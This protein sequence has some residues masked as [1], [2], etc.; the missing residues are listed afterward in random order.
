[1]KFI[2]DRNQTKKFKNISAVVACNNL[3]SYSSG[4]NKFEPYTNVNRYPTLRTVN[5]PFYSKKLNKPY[6]LYSIDRVKSKHRL[7]F[8]KSFKL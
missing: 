1:M 5:A 6:K 3:L 7:N 2:T 8:K 4:Y